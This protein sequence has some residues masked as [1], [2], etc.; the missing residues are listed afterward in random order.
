MQP[1]RIRPSSRFHTLCHWTGQDVLI[2][3]LDTTA[4]DVTRCSLKCCFTNEPIPIPMC[5]EKFISP[6]LRSHSDTQLNPRTG[7]I[8]PA[9]ITRI[10]T[11]GYLTSKVNCDSTTFPVLEVSGVAQ[12]RTRDQITGS[13]L[14][15]SVYLSGLRSHMAGWRQAPAADRWADS[16]TA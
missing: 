12:G 1:D 6:T 10:C 2:S 3:D 16:V 11:L 13:T 8:M 5:Y 4:L 9:L 7:I 14:Y 15:P